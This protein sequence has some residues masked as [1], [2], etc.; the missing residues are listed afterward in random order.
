[1]ATTI[2]QSNAIVIKSPAE[3]LGP[4]SPY[5]QRRVELR[6]EYAASLASAKT[7]TVN[8]LESCEEAVSHGQLL[9]VAVTETEKFFKAIKQQIDNIKK[10]VLEAEKKDI[11]PYNVEKDRLG[12]EVTVWRAEQRRIQAESERKAREEAEAAAREAQLLAAI[13]LEELGD[14]QG[15]VQLLEEPVFTPPVVVR[16]EA[17]VK[18]AG[19]VGKLSYSTRLVDLRELLKAILE[20]KAPLEAITWNESHCNALARVQKESF[21]M[22]GVELQKTESTHFRA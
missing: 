11:G 20:G 19:S 9:Q 10:P 1:M 5:E 15:A 14:T 17:P 2:V 13:D 22:P 6:K 4:A 3:L 12:R 21:H 18:M 8:S 16:A 7:I